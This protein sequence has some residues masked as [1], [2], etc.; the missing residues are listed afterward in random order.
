[1]KKIIPLTFLLILSACASH[2]QQTYA[3]GHLQPIIAWDSLNTADPCSDSLF[4]ALQNKPYTQLTAYEQ[5]Y[6]KQKW[7]ECNGTPEVNHG[8]TPEWILAAF[9]IAGLAVAIIIAL[10]G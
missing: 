3:G 1:M 5:A 2:H 10:V 8:S 9:D 4:L 6:F 7:D